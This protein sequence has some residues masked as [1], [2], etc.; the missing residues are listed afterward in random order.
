MKQL[1]EG[2]A[3]D[4]VAQGRSVSRGIWC[5]ALCDRGGD[6]PACVSRRRRGIGCR[7]HQVE[8]I[9]YPGKGVP[10]NNLGLASATRKDPNVFAELQPRAMESVPQTPLGGRVLRAAG[11]HGTPRCL[12]GRPGLPSLRHRS[13]AHRKPSWHA[14]GRPSSRATVPRQG[15]PGGRPVADLPPPSMPLGKKPACNQA[16]PVRWNSRCHAK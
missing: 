5:P 16:C 13:A 2:F 3:T 14:L 8:P 12:S 11:L 15:P 7:R 6:S 10:S 9:S 4:D 1:P